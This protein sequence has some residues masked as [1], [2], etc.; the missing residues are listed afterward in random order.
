[1]RSFSLKFL[2]EMTIRQFII[3]VVLSF[4][5]NNIYTIKVQVI[6][7]TPTTN[8]R[9]LNLYTVYPKI[10][11]CML[12]SLSVGITGLVFENVESGVV[13]PIFGLVT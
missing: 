4:E 11:I 1:M 8:K 12:F 5:K 3:I 13:T 6:K 2:S 10:I 7:C 9:Y